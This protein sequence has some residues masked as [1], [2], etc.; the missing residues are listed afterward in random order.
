MSDS[1]KSLSVK[2]F[3]DLIQ[4]TAVLIV[5]VENAKKYA[6]SK[7]DGLIHQV[8][9]LERQHCRE[10]DELSKKYSHEIDEL[11]RQHSHQIDE[12][13]GVISA[14]K[15]ENNDFIVSLS[16]L[17]QEME[18]RERQVANDADQIR[19]ENVLAKKQSESLLLQL[20][21]L[22]ESLEN[23]ECDRAAQLS[24]SRAIVIALRNLEKEKKENQGKFE[25]FASLCNRQSKALSD[26]L[27]KFS[28]TIPI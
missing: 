11:S 26:L 19:K 2:D 6:Q 9:E 27:V 15:V 24:Q 20:H 12:L 23:A 10:I 22:Q 16:S 7:L 14:L 3:C 28:S 8:S 5:E 17:R 25:L 1:T 21:G 13:N 18:L 4:R